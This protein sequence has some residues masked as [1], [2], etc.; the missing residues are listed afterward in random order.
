MFGLW[1]KAAGQSLS[2]AVP[3]S[4]LR[5]RTT[6]DEDVLLFQRNVLLSQAPNVVIA[7]ASAI[8]AG[9]FAS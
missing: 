5:D 2:A 1:S 7:V 3:G 4:A 8:D 9:V 6:P